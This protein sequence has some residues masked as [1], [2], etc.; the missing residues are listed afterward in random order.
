MILPIRTNVD[1]KKTPYMN[2][3]IIA[4]NIAI[5]LLSWYPVKTMQGT[6]DTLRPWAQAFQLSPSEP[7]LHQFVTY[8][9]LHSGIGH[10]LG[11]MFF[12][13]IFGNNVND[14]LGHLGYL[15][16][17]LAGG[18]FAGFG[19]CLIHGSD[20]PLV[21]AS[22]AIAAVTGAYLVLFPQTLIT[23]V[24]WFLIIGTFD[25][26]AFYFIGFKM[27]VWD[28]VIER[29]T[30][31]VAYD[32]HL[33]GYLFGI[34]SIMLMLGTGLIQRSAFDMWSMLKR[35]NQRRQFRQMVEEGFDGSGRAKKVVARQRELTPQQEQQIR[36]I[37]QIRDQIASYIDSGNMT[38]AAEKYIELTRLD[39]AQ[40]LGRAQMLDVANQLMAMSKWEE[41][42][43]AYEKFLIH[44]S[45][46][47]YSEQVELMLG[48]V[49][50]RYLKKNDLAAKYLERAQIRLKDPGQKKMCLDELDRLKQHG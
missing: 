49:Y 28:N 29:R 33:A 6:M 26:P 21:G 25:L 20:I 38:S 45:S 30:H 4:A 23:V 44:Y 12:L 19:H 16:F 47:H 7:A 22:G 35:W 32:A 50:A 34:L 37:Q 3:A 8:A 15:C 43:E 39:S 11:N 31:N 36:D 24:W 27:I 13:F 48:V 46:Y 14:K 42:A 40:V 1:L 2:Y 17:Y 10:I 18:I 5:F 41:C 9:F